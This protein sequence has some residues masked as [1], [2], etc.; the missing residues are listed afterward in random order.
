MNRNPQFFVSQLGAV[1]MTCLRLRR[2]VQLW[3]HL[4]LQPLCHL[5]LAGCTEVTTPKMLKNVENMLRTSGT[6]I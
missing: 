1:T 4:D 3:F 5:V 2:V 6:H